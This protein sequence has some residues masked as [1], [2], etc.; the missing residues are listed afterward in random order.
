[1]YIDMRIIIIIIIIIIIFIYLNKYKD[2]EHF[3]Q[4]VDG[5]TR[6]QCGIMCTKILDCKAFA[7]DAENKYCYLSKDDILFKPIKKTFL[8]ASASL[9]SLRGFEVGVIPLSRR[10]AVSFKERV[11]PSILWVL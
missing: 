2:K 8:W 11:L 10:F 4:R 6:E 7:H 5:A 9:T 1:M 3:D